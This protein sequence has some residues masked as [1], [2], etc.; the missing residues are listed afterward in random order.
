M[1]ISNFILNY[2]SACVYYSIVRHIIILNVLLMPY[3]SNPGKICFD[4]SDKASLREW[5]GCTYRFQSSISDLAAASAFGTPPFLNLPFR[6]A[7][8]EKNS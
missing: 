3:Y 6:L 5:A 4:V 2:V 8:R 7:K 1:K